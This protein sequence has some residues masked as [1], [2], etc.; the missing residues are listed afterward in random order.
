MLLLP[1]GCVRREGRNSDC[2]WP[3]TL[4]PRAANANHRDLTAD[5]EFAEELAIRY[6]EAHYGPRDLAAAAK[7]KNH[8]MGLLLEEIGKERGITAKEAFT[9]FGKRNGAA[10]IAMNLPFLLLYALA[11]DFAIRRLVARYP[12]GE[13]WMT[14]IAMLLLASMALG[15]MGLMVGQQWSE[16]AESIRVGSTHLSVRGSRLPVNKH[17]GEAFALAVALFLGIA[18]LRSW[19]KRNVPRP[20]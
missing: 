9:S 3:R 4:E 14:S 8:C 10:D 11:A 17:P 7:A 5:L 18:V 16:L 12:P 6:M 19:G 13:G 1:S 2:Q 20:E 15:A